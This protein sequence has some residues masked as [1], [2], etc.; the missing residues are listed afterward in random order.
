MEMMTVEV[1]NTQTDFGPIYNGM[2]VEIYSAPAKLVAVGSV[3]GEPILK[4][5]WVPSWWPFPWP[6]KYETILH[7]TCDKTN[8]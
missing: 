8:G 2:P 4:R 1:D 3:T 7:I 6:A 5:T